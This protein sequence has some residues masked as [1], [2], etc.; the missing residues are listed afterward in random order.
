MTAETA[1]Q[2]MLTPPETDPAKSPTKR[3]AAFRDIG[4]ILL[5][6]IIFIVLCFSTP[7]FFT[8]DNLRNVL[9]GAVAVGLIACAGTV[10]IIA[11]GFD[12]SA[13]SI[14]A[15]AAIS[16]ALITNSSGNG[17]LGVLGG[18]GIGLVLG[19]VNGLLVSV[20]RIS[21]FVGTL[22]TMIAYAGLAT[23][24]SGSGLILI[25]DPSF[26][27]FA[28][29]QFLGLRTSAWIFVVFAIA[30]SIML[31]FT[32]FGRHVYASGGNLSAAR[33]SGVSINK[34]II[35][36]YILSGGAAALAGLITAASSLSVS[37]NSGMNLIFSALAAILIG[38]NSM[39]GGRGAIWRTLVGVATLALISNG[40]NLMGVNPIF[41]QIVSG[42]IILLAVGVDAWTRRRV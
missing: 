9:V 10:V 20:G 37:S 30:C 35:A 4:I 6:I 22:A 18:L 5:P 27:T 13:G 33:L 24:L 34:T 17:I 29:T 19:L 23:V 25:S 15:V 3:I 31:N 8:V 7:T 28:N 39:L 14:F 42:A 21:H 36:A 2:A 26:A 1:T 16:G 32:V 41:Q 11:G 12:L 40:F 38:G